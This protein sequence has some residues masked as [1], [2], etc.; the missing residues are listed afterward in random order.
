MGTPE[1]GSNTTELDR[2]NGLGMTFQVRLLEREVGKM[3]YLPRL[4]HAG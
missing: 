4:K 1:T 3:D 2:G